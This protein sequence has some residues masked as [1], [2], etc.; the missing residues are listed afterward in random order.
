MDEHVG[1]PSGNDSHFANWKMANDIVS[2]PMKAMV[3]FHSYVK[4]P[5]GILFRFIDVFLI[6]IILPCFYLVMKVFSLMN[7]GTLKGISC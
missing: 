4:S 6:K 2:F 5:E 1:I 7:Y 3:I